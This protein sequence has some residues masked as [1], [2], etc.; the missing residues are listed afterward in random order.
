MEIGRV[1]QFLSAIQVFIVS[2]FTGKFILNYYRSLF[3]NAGYGQVA[4]DFSS[5]LDDALFLALVFWHS[6]LLIC[7][8]SIYRL[9]SGRGLRTQ[10]NVLIYSFIVTYGVA[11]ILWINSL[12]VGL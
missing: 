6:A 5:F 9:V 2:I 1:V 12:L 11:L 10:I 4:P 8:V 3:Y 7:M